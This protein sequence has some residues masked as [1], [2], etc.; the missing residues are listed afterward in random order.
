MTVATGA[1]T[2]M[3]NDARAVD[4]S[5]TSAVD[6]DTVAYVEGWLGITNRKGASGDTVSLT[7]DNRAYQFTVPSGL[8][9]A[10]GDVVYITVA[11]LT[12]H[13]PQD[14][15]YTTTSGAGKVPLFKAQKA[16]DSNNMV[17]G[18]LISG[19]GVIS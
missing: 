13:Y 16:K 7:V 12:G 1:Q 9:V 11:T 10:K 6:K 8:A 3:D 15:A 14:S 18:R 17:I 4:V 19:L 2:W 5:L